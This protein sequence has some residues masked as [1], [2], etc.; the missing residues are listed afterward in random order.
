[1]LNNCKD[2][3]MKKEKSPIDKLKEEI[4]LR[5]R[6]YMY[7][8]LQKQ[9]IL[10]RMEK[11]NYNIIMEAIEQLNIDYKDYQNYFLPVA[12]YTISIAEFAEVVLNPVLVMVLDLTLLEV[13]ES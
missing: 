4:E 10:N 12:T 9:Y 8:K 7:R 11:N 2:Y 3:Q 1:M 5:H 13:A 6:M